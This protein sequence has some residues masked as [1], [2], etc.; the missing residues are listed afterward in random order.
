MQSA[1]KILEHAGRRVGDFLT[2]HFARRR[3]DAHL[4]DAIRYASLA[5]GKR[6]RP[7]LVYA[8]ARILGL[9]DDRVDAVAAS[10]ELIHTYSL[11]H[12]D[13]PSMD[14][15]DYRRGQLSCHKQYNEALAIL[16]GDAMQAMAFEVL[17][18]PAH[19][20]AG[21]AVAMVNILSRHIGTE[22]MA[23]G[24]A[25]DV[26]PRDAPPGVDEIET[27]HR[28]KTGALMEACI[29]MTLA[30]AQDADAA[31]KDALEAYA[32]KIG[33]CFQIKDDLLDDP[34]ENEA[35]AATLTAAM[36]RTDCEKRLAELTAQS[37]ECL[38]PLD[39]KAEPLRVLTRYIAERDD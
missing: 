10:V 24:Q 3:N 26:D 5:P 35:H 27:I 15:D 13:L 30:C 6:I 18:Q 29:Q 28:L 14:D 19:F 32:R 21:Q 9:A 39:G 25:L 34:H 4:L 33:V 36:S 22:G 17:T 7:C 16:A 20:S 31:R 37:L 38:A 23:G 11:I 2:A 1:E 8:S 12:D